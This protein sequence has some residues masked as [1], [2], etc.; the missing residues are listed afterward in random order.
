MPNCW[1][2]VASRRQASPPTFAPPSLQRPASRGA[3]GAG[4]R[5]RPQTEEPWTRRLSACC[6]RAGCA[7]RKLRRS[8]GPT[9]RTPPTAAAYWSTSAARKRPK[10]TP[11]RT[12]ATSRTGAPGRFANTATRSRCSGQGCARSRPTKCSAASTD[13]PSPAACGSGHGRRHR[14]RITGT[15][16]RRPR[17]R[18]YRPWGQHHRDYACRRL[19]KRPARMVVHYSAVAAAEQG[20]VAKYL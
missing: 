16:A 3:P 4:W 7:G 15:Q 6:C 17:L 8:A 12:C 1:L 5:V 19:E 13:S 2:G 10:M 20:A 14:R 11:P 18:A 9:C